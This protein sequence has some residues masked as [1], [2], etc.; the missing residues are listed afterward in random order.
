MHPDDGYQR[1]S[2]I[3]NEF[4]EFCR[5][6]GQVS[7]ADT[8]AKII[9]RIL[10]ETLGW[11]ESTIGREDPVH[12][13]YLDYLFSPVAGRGLVVVEAKREGIPFDLPIEKSKKPT[14][15]QLNKSIRTHRDA[16]EAIEQ[17]QRYCVEKAV[18]YAV[19]TNGYAWIIFR[20]LREDIP[21]RE[22]SATVYSSASTIKSNFSSFWNLLSYDAI[23]SGKLEAA[24]SGT[25]PVARRLQR[26]L[27]G[28]RNANQLLVRNRLHT[29]LNPLIERI[30][31]DIAES[32]QIE[33]LERCYVRDKTLWILD[34]DLKNG[35][36]GLCSAVC[37]TRGHH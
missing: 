20:A 7:E 6:R 12:H 9:D 21:W 25:P 24:F 2:E 13:G 1:L 17:A 15:Y 26:P 23:T 29:Q 5:R 4:A 36:R 8:R 18:R 16:Y 22:G 19:V 11:P 27:D 3:Y 14:S 32:D 30:F 10:K 37:S 35:N 28:L 34:K 33:I 31:G